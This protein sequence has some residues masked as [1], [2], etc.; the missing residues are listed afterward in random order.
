[1]GKGQAV[2]AML[3]FLK[4]LP[5]KMG[6]TMSLREVQQGGQYQVKTKD[7]DSFDEANSSSVLS[8]RPTR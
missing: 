1:M 2:K 3:T 4:A 6:V 5:I 7:L 8:L